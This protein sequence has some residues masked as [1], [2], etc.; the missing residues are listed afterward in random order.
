MEEEEGGTAFTAL[1]RMERGMGFSSKSMSSR[2]SS[3]RGA[4]GEE[5]SAARGSRGGELISLS[6]LHSL[7]IW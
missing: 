5:F 1:A 7:A 4:D 2:S 6:V 3:F